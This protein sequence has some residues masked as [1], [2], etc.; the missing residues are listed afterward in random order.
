MKKI[1]GK[2]AVLVMALALVF[3]L[4]ACGDDD[5]GNKGK[6]DK[7]IT[8]TQLLNDS[9]DA[10][11]AKDKIAIEGEV[12]INFNNELIKGI[13]LD[14]S[15]IVN[16]V[17]GDYNY[18]LVAGSEQM[19]KVGNKVYLYSVANDNWLQESTETLS[20][21]VLKAQLLQYTSLLEEVPNKAGKRRRFDFGNTVGNRK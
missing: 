19:M 17:S 21:E 6:T 4:A 12:S 9:V 5:S 1:L 14:L 18:K 11:L 3:S 2:I 16:K 7:P 20:P 15:A 8:T 13:D 10:T